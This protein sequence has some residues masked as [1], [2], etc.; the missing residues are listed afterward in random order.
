M[1]MNG[2][3]PGEILFVNPSFPYIA[4]DGYSREALRPPHPPPKADHRATDSSFL[5]F[6]RDLREPGIPSRE[7]TEE[8]IGCGLGK[9]GLYK[10]VIFVDNI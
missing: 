7:G 5:Y 9:T 8:R 1:I 2:T 6:E 4:W 10:R 3:L